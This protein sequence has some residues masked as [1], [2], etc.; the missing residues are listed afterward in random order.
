L[1]A[2]I[3]SRA[4]AAVIANIAA[5]S[6]ALRP[7]VEASRIPARRNRTRSLVVRV[8]LTRRSASDGESSR[9]N[10]PAGRAIA[11]TSGD[12]LPTLKILIKPDYVANV[13]CRSTSEGCPTTGVIGTVS[14]PVGGVNSGGP[15]FRREPRSPSACGPM[16]LWGSGWREG[17]PRA[18]GARRG[19]DPQTKGGVDVRDAAVLTYLAERGVEGVPRPCG[20]DDEDRH[21]L[22]FLPG[23][24][25][26]DRVPCPDWVWS[27]DLLGD[28]G[29]WLRRLHDQTAE[30]VHCREPAPGSRRYPPSSASPSTGCSP[31][32][33][34]PT[35]AT[36]ASSS[37]GLRAG[38]AEGPRSPCAEEPSGGR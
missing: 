31:G 28:V 13:P 1:N 6:V 25:V 37:S 3:T 36:R 19:H 18:R 27:W 7:W 8:I 35:P 20:V 34:S 14:P 4:Y 11:T 29:R 16:R 32:A 9:T 17:G 5:A 2:W 38:A 33:A 12:S 15:P 22:T 23:D 30:F 24:T 21:V 10:T 26:G